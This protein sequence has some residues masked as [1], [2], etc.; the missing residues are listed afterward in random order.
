MI[1][2]R[3]RFAGLLAGS[4]VSCGAALAGE[5][6]GAHPEFL[7]REQTLTQAVSLARATPLPLGDR[8]GAQLALARFYASHGLHAEALAALGNAETAGAGIEALIVK[9]EQS[10]GM[11]RWRRVIELTDG[12]QEIEL[13]RLRAIAFSNLGADRKAATVFAQIAPMLPAEHFLA[14]DERF[15]RARAAL[16]VGDG[17]EA[18]R[19]VMEAPFAGIPVE[20][21]AERRLILAHARRLSGDVAAAREDY[22]R[23]SALAPDAISIEAQI[24]ALELDC[25]AAKDCLDAAES[26]LWKWRG[27][28][29]ERRV[30]LFLGRSA[31]EAGST[32]KGFSALRILTD[33][34]FEADEAQE[35]RALLTIAMT[36]LFA[37]DSGLGPTEAASIFRANLD[38]AP[39]GRA[40]DELIR[41]AAAHLSALGLDAEAAAL[42]DHQVFRRLRGEERSR[43]AIDL[44]KAHLAAG[45]PQSALEAI[46]S[47]R[48]AGL[49]PED[50][51]TRIALEARALAAL[52]RLDEAIE[53]A[54]G[55]PEDEIDLM[56][57]EFF[58]T[59]GIW[60]R[61]ATAYAR[62]AETAA[63]EGDATAFDTAS[64]RA[65]AAFLLSDDPEGFAA[66]AEEITHRRGGSPR[67]DLLSALGKLG[68]SDATDASVME[69][70][71][72]AFASRDGS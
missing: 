20:R 30:R 47:T 29:G 40:G 6:A 68:A 19:L 4:V 36:A 44:A 70:Y 37:D 63:R 38:L 11:G 23:L 45:A 69:A 12:A 39:P 48:I 66:F 32:E 33:K 2:A 55:A 62:L 31:L 52:G 15:A 10:A 7:A 21:D 24:A 17:S 1:R 46:R 58:W 28:A 35:A 51:R 61:A 53:L 41:D 25:P 56:H 18:M 13:R 50:A 59:A 54:A 9:A 14:H 64:L 34:N 71:R 26:L 22:R 67:R 42:L 16:A 60:S 72:K 49:N 3:S 27:G 5:P 43:V 57:A 8:A 65:G